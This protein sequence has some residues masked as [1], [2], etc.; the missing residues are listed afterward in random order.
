MLSRAKAR[1]NIKEDIVAICVGI[2]LAWVLIASGVFAELLASTDAGKIFESFFVGLFFTS[3]FTL[4]PAAIFLAEL[5]QTVSPW[6]VALFGALGAM[7]GDLV[8]FLFIR[9]RLADDI[10]GMFPK[11]AVR[12]FLNSFHLGFWKWLAPILGALIIASP[13]PDEFGVSLLGLSR[14]KVAVLLPVAFVMNF[15]GIL[16]VAAAVSAL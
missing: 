9:D 4:A 7:C 1:V 6:L 10:K 13:L 11:T 2:F 5:S 8:L 15:L 16:A 3:V 14:V 12:R